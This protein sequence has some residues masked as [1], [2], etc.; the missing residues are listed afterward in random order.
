MLDTLLNLSITDHLEMDGQIER[1]NQVSKDKLQAYIS[2]R[3]LNWEDY[4]PILEFAYN[5]V[6]HVNKSMLMYSFQ[7]RSPVKRLG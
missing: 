4:F 1:V 2:K 7:P 6:K 3:Q 5:S